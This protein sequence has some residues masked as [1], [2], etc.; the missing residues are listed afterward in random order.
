MINL[1]L[2]SIYLNNSSFKDFSPEIPDNFCQWL[3]LDI[4]IQGD[5]KSSIFS[6]CVCTPKWILH[7]FEDKKFFWGEAMMIIEEFNH[8]IIEK[9]IKSTLLFC[10][11]N[12]WETSLLYLLRFF[13]WEFEEFQ[14]RI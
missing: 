3:D 12:N 1:E 5:E 14:E 8:E 10:S 2:K 9:E 13:T 4:G 11:R 6:F 7:N